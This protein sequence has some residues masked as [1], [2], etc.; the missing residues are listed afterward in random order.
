V[1]Q[2]G[3]VVVGIA[4]LGALLYLRSRRTTPAASDAPLIG[5]PLT[6]DVS[7][8]GGRLPTWRG[9]GS[10]PWGKTNA[11]GSPATDAGGGDDASSGDAGSSI[12]AGAGIGLGTEAA[13]TGASFALG[14]SSGGRGDAAPTGGGSTSIGT[15]IGGAHHVIS[16][17]TGKPGQHGGA[18]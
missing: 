2:S 12:F 7:G 4:G 15:A 9:L 5:H 11:D 10:L 17:P 8:T 13:D 1:K 16:V 3:A 18:L 14:S 6:V